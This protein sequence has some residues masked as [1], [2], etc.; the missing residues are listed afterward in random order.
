MSETPEY[1]KEEIARRANDLLADPIL[2]FVLAEV[3]RRYMN[4]WRAAK[5]DDT[6]KREACW[7]GV[8][9]LEDIYTQINSMAAA[10]KVEAFN[11][12]LRAKHK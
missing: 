11:K 3:E 12:G 1:T 5:I 4:D 6:A 9:S 2:Q 10:P 7:L 8:K